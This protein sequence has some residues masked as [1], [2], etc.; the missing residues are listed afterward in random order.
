M[1]GLLVLLVLVLISIAVWQLVKIFD[2]TQIG[3]G[4]DED[5]QIATDNDNRVNGNLMF[6]FWESSISL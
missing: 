1:T 5:S 3:V 6:A 2:L 4:N